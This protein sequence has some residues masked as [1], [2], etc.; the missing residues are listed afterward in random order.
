MLSAPQ[1]DGDNRKQ[2]VR[3]RERDRGKKDDEKSRYDDDDDLKQGGR[4]RTKKEKCQRGN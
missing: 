2:E 3:Q 4:E 1:I